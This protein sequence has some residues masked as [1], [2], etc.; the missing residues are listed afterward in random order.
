MDVEEGIKDR[1]SVQYINSCE[2]DV[3]GKTC[4]TGGWLYHLTDFYSKTC[5]AIPW[6]NVNAYW[7][8]ADASCDT[9]CASIGTTPNYP[10]ACIDEVT[11]PTHGLGGG[12]GMGQAAA[13]A[14]IKDVLQQDRAVWFGFFVPTPSAW[15]DFCSF[16][17]S[18]S[19][20]VVYDIDQF[21]GT[22]YGDGAGHAVLCV[23][24]NDDDP[25]NEYWIMLNSWGTTP[26]R[27]NGF[28]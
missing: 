19:E 16:W 28:Q 9:S 17:S 11:V 10:V 2:H 21:C 1:L 25:D 20:S 24:Y 18:D 26:S 13:I 6:S 3:I 22:P 23:G 14:N 5:M 27:P 12:E 15:N 8:D 7:Q 4:C